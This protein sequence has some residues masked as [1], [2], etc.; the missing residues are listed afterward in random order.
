MA[1]TYGQLL[2]DVKNN[3]NLKIPDGNL[4]YINNNFARCS[5]LIHTYN[6]AIMLLEEHAKTNPN[7]LDD[8][9]EVDYTKIFGDRDGALFATGNYDILLENYARGVSDDSNAVEYKRLSDLKQPIPRDLQLKC[10]VGAIKTIAKELEGEQ[11]INNFLFKENSSPMALGS[12]EE[13]LNQYNK[14]TSNSKDKI[15]LADFSRI[16]TGNMELILERSNATNDYEM[17]LSSGKLNYYKLDLD[18]N[19]LDAIDML[20]YDMS[21]NI[22]TRKPDMPDYARFVVEA[23]EVKEVYRYGDRY[24]NV[25]DR[26]G[27]KY[28][29]NNA[30]EVLITDINKIAYAIASTNEFSV[31]LVD[32]TGK[33][34]EWDENTRPLI[35]EYSQLQGQT[36]DCVA[37][38]AMAE[39]PFDPNNQIAL[40]EDIKTAMPSLYTKEI[41]AVPDAVYTNKFNVYA[42]T[43]SLDQT[44]SY[45]TLNSVIKILGG[46]YGIEPT[47]YTYKN[48]NKESGK[49]DSMDGGSGY[50][51]IKLDQISRDKLEYMLETR[52][53]LAD[54]NN[55]DLGR[56]LS[57]YLKLDYNELVGEV[58]AVSTPIEK[59]G[60]GTSVLRNIFAENNYE[61]IFA[62]VKN[63]TPISDEQ[64]SYRILLQGINELSDQNGVLNGSPVDNIEKF[65]AIDQQDYLDI[66]QKEVL[67]STFAKIIAMNVF[68]RASFLI[69]KFDYMSEIYKKTSR[70]S[71]SIKLSR[72]TLQELIDYSNDLKK[73]LDNTEIKSYY[74]KDLDSF[75]KKAVSKSNDINKDD[76][77]MWFKRG[78]Y[79]DKIITLVNELAD[80]AKG[81]LDTASSRTKNFEISTKGVDENGD[82]IDYSVD[83]SP[84][85]LKNPYYITNLLNSYDANSKELYKD[86]KSLLFSG[87]LTARHMSMRKI[88]LTD[89]DDFAKDIFPNSDNLISDGISYNDFINTTLQLVSILSFAEHIVTKEGKA[90]LES[91][92][93]GLRSLLSDNDPEVGKS[94]LWVLFSPDSPDTKQ[95]EDGT[96]VPG[97]KT[98]ITKSLLDVY[99][100]SI[101]QRLAKI[102]TIARA[103]LKD[104]VS[105]NTMILGDAIP[106][107]TSRALGLMVDGS[108][109]SQIKAILSVGVAGTGKT[110][111][112]KTIDSISQVSIETTQNNMEKENIFQGRTTDATVE[113]GKYMWSINPS[114]I[115]NAMGYHV[116]ASLEDETAQ[117]VTSM[118]GSDDERFSNDAKTN[119]INQ[120]TGAVPVASI[121]VAG[122]DI[123]LYKNPSAHT[124]NCLDS[125]Y[126]NA[127]SHFLQRYNIEISSGGEATTSKVGIK[128]AIY[129]KTTADAVKF[130]DNSVKE[131]NIERYINAS[132]TFMS[133]YI[134]TFEEYASGDHQEKIQSLIKTIKDI[135]I[136]LRKEGYIDG[137]GLFTGDFGGENPISKSVVNGFML[138]E[139][140]ETK[141]YS[142]PLK[143]EA[144]NILKE[145]ISQGVLDNTLL[146]SANDFLS[147]AIVENN[148]KNLRNLKNSG[149]KIDNVAYYTNL[150]KK[151]IDFYTSPKMVKLRDDRFNEFKE[152]QANGEL[153]FMPMNK[154]KIE[155]FIRQYEADRASEVENIK[156]IE[157]YNKKLIDTM[158][159]SPNIFYLNQS[160]GGVAR[161]MTSNPARQENFARMLKILA[162]SKNSF[163]VKSIDILANMVY[164]VN[165]IMQY[166]NEYLLSLGKKSYDAAEDMTMGHRCLYA[167]AKK[168]MDEPFIPLSKETFYKDFGVVNPPR[169]RNGIKNIDA[170]ELCRNIIEQS[171]GYYNQLIF[172]QTGVKTGGLDNSIGRN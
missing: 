84:K 134:K 132:N 164:D 139:H 60:M 104:S 65:N 93:S 154:G 14:L 24:L 112:I 7:Y 35:K 97:D 23:D 113:Q 28:Y 62:K 15:N 39:F 107:V 128:R 168:I 121:K 130:I 170:F 10:F 45:L 50:G 11:G 91:I 149:Y 95:L 55:I 53:E 64:L 158:A 171:L 26:D 81:M 51:P 83:P 144:C 66:E 126:E 92:K 141:N 80:E 27:D 136:E 159:V 74:E 19:R 13:I 63:A 125:N 108:N 161:H 3:P 166:R 153:A 54:L 133:N 152:K 138:R 20:S 123:N 146:N 71:F 41:F 5:A 79:N 147:S 32:D 29:I 131:P 169:D 89:L 73:F 40:L 116:N 118:L 102:P 109:E 101:F 94:R 36:R 160:L 115:V 22:I 165:K 56:T 9:K 96:F 68:Q 119:Q 49:A 12:L 2:D 135:A 124:G 31:S 1:I 110:H 167:I 151:E 46:T 155:R 25:I 127:P 106:A 117:S 42:P 44:P 88:I 17:E 103:Y 37:G 172:N 47:I 129:Q 114:A 156:K 140:L 4:L 137:A 90:E 122:I 85:T 145:L 21:H 34:L 77:N 75:I 76:Y 67:K 18:G 99:Y 48:D 6:T 148:L 16:V 70:S 61:N 143:Q 87:A 150:A 72:E 52:G 8:N 163:E 33:A 162:L 57:D 59:N 111:I 120:S 43:A 157:H 86:L 30:K 105:P 58:P 69:A 82:E 78:L 100:P 142:S 38:F 98:E